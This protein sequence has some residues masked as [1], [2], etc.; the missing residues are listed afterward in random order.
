MEHVGILGLCWAHMGRMEKNMETTIM[1]YIKGIESGV[2]EDL[3]R[4]L[5]HDKT[6]KSLT[7]K[8]TCELSG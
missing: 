5:E 3:M 7:A 6:T 1:G 2:Y 8:K 4:L